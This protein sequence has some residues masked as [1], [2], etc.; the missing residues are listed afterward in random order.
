M[1]LE[2]YHQVWHMK[3]KKIMLR[4]GFFLLNSFERKHI[5]KPVV[6]RQEEG[7][8]TDRTGM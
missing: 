4:H 8:T 1:K 5:S 2:Q 7:K 3:E 6:G